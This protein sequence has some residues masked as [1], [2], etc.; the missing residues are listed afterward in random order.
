MKTDLHTAASRGHA[1]HEW[2]ESFHTFSFGGYQNPARMNFGV[3]RVLNDDTVAAAMGFGTHPHRNMEIISI[4]LAGDLEHKDNTGTHAIIRNGELQ[5]MSAGTGIEHS[6]YNANQDKEV[7]FLQ[8]W[9]IPKK[10]EVKP[11]YQQILLNQADREN[12]LEQILSPN[13]TD[14]GV[15]IYQNAWFHLGKL[16]EGTELTHEL[17]DPENNGLYA[18]VLSGD[19]TVE[20]QLLNQRDG[21]GLTEV[22]SVQLKA[23]TDTEILLMEVPMAV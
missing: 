8:I 6:E 22:S 23:Q 3:L 11:R 2:L 12:K 1:N 7:Q 21:F 19:I 16:T 15:W 9:I 20:G 14:A 18:F 4:P 17:K 10:K 13:K 5:V